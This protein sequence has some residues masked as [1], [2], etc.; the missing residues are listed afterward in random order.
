VI[1]VPEMM[2]AAATDLATIDSD[3]SAAHSAAAKATVALVPA[4]ADEVSVGIAHLFSE[5]AQGF[6][7][8]AAQAS[9]FHGQF[10]LHLKTG[11]G[12]YSA[13][14]AHSAANLFTDIGGYFLYMLESPFIALASGDLVGFLQRLLWLPVGL[15]AGAV[16]FGF[17][18]APLIVVLP[19][20]LITSLIDWL[21]GY[22]LL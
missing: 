16:I 17:L 5:H 9:V 18:L 11:A 20:A 8:L 22:P 13:A 21:V 2:T 19:F 7:A 4:A 15:V 14:E 1:A 12:A 6:H 10:A 3:L